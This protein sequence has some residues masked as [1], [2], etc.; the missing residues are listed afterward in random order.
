MQANPQ[1]KKK[2]SFDLIDIF[3]NI[4]STRKKTNVL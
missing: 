3:I 2:N 1:K 4:Q